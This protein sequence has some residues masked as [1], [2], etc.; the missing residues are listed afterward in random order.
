VS[1][2]QPG[3]YR[4]SAGGM[5]GAM[6]VLVAVVLGFVVF[7]ELNRSDPASPVDEVDYTRTVEFARGEAGFDLLAP[8]SLPDGWLATSVN[9]VPGDDGRW[10]LGML[11]DE[12]QY[13]GLEQS[14][15]SAESMVETHVDQDARPGGVVV[16]DGDQWR[17]WT[18]E[19]GDVALVRST[20]S[21][22]T[23][24]VGHEVPR[25]ELAAFAS[26]LR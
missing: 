10:H 20:G 15:G 7:R 22:T 9:F 17:A 8:P 14:S 19:G 18:D 13:V 23:L 24:V 4:R 12:D 21:T 16:V 26:S 5:A 6:V 1:E 11:T 2:Q 25:A 3:R